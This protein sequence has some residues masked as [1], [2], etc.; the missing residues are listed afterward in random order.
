MSCDAARRADGPVEVV[1]CGGGGG[2][3]LGVGDHG[4]PG[5]AV[6]SIKRWGEKIKR[7]SMKIRLDGEESGTARSRSKRYRM[8]KFQR[9]HNGVTAQARKED[10]PSTPSL[11]TH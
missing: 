11:P 3:G 9:S 4:V 6:R 7:R 10:N 5:Y 8:P 1:S 2:G